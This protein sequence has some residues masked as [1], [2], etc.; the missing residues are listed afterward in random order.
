MDWNVSRESVRPGKS[1]RT[2]S[3]CGAVETPSEQLLIPLWALN[4][5]KLTRCCT[6]LVVETD[7]TP[8]AS[9]VFENP[10][11]DSRQNLRSKNVY[12]LP[13]RTI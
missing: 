8:C 1:L 2:A 6:N 12:V 9:V 7:R 13:I 5:T 3:D 11:K 4:I 10:N